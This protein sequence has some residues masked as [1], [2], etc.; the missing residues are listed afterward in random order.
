MS[1]INVKTDFGAVGD[2]VTN[3]TAAINNALAQ[4]L[5]DGKA[6]YFP[7]ALGYSVREA[8][9][10]AGYAILN[11]GTSM[12]GP[13]SGAKYCNINV[14][15]SFPT[16]CPIMYW[17]PLV[18]IEFCTLK[19]FSI[20]PQ[21]RG[22][23]AINFL[24]DDPTN[25]AFLH[26]EGLYFY[27][28]ND[29]SIFI[30]NYPSINPQ[31]CPS[32]T[33]IENSVIKSGIYTAHLGDNFVV[34]NNGI[35]GSPSGYVC[36]AHNINAAAGAASHFKFESN[37]VSGANGILRV[38]QAYNIKILYN[39]MESDSGAGS[40][41]ALIDIN[42]GI[43]QITNCDIIGNTLGIFGA[44]T[45][46]TGIRVANADNTFIDRN[47]IKASG[48]GRAAGIKVVAGATN[49]RIGGGNKITGFTATVSNAGTG[50]V[51][52]P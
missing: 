47:E 41:G 49:T 12:I 39:E 4:G 43:S 19:N 27:V 36:F 6:V 15:S 9:A 42:G 29:Y 25:I 45:H 16:N 37:A 13:E 31:G 40:N 50:T 24:L 7:P 18:D 20:N 10:G 46:S 2:N 52:L 51:T 11:R 32:N 38:D 44:S 1:V 35:G 23:N 8:Y 26:M 30:Q 3:D 48:S 28:G 5:L 17:S 34:R 14:H 33:V 21:G 22:T